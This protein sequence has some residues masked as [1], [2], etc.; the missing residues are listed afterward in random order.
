MA[1]ALYIGLSLYYTD[2]FS[3]GTWVNA[4]YCTGKTVSEVHMELAQADTY[5]KIVLLLPDGKKES[6]QMGDISY[7]ADFT[8][9]LLEIRK[10]Q[11]S[12]KWYEN[13]SKE[14]PK[15]TIVPDISFDE[16]KLEEILSSMDFLKNKKADDAYRVFIKKTEQGYVLVNERMQVP[17]ENACLTAVKEAI[18]LKK[19]QIDLKEEGCYKSLPLTDAMKET[20]KLWE[21]LDHFQNSGISYQ[22]GEECVPIDAASASGWLVTAEG[23]DSLQ[24]IT[25]PDAFLTEEDGRFLVDKDKIEAYVDSLADT[26]DTVG[27]KR[28]FQTTQSGWIEVSGGTYGN[29]LD[30]KTEK[31]YLCEIFEKQEFSKQKTQIHTPSYIQTAW[32]QGRDDIGDTYIEIDMGKQK[33]YYYENGEKKLETEIVTGDMKRKR[34]TPEM[35]CYVYAKQKNR[36]LRGPG[37]ASF[38]KYWMPVKGGIGIHDARWRKEFGGEI[39]QTQ[40]SHGCINLPSDQAKALYEQVEIGTPVIMFYGNIS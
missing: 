1:A 19:E 36:T 9:A 8:K 24:Y 35:V 27:A 31:T 3:Y 4:V 40:G 29:L 33:L 7:R 13:L 22:F 15:R 37:Y 6:I 39:Y 28:Q 18:L 10:E 2:G 20:L 32:K 26:Y 38:V 11:N 12:W 21:K 34:Q 5:E 16:E 14:M 23:A 25:S 30:R 17:D